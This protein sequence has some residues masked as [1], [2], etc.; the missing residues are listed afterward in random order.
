MD[1]FQ[2]FA[3]VDW[4]KHCLACECSLHI[5]IRSLR[6]AQLSYA[7]ILL[8]QFIYT[9]ALPLVQGSTSTILKS[10]SEPE[11]FLDRLWLIGHSYYPG[12]TLF[13]TDQVK[14]P[15]PFSEIL[16]YRDEIEAFKANHPRPHDPEHVET[17]STRPRR[18]SSEL[19]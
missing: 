7:K 17:T 9:A 8:L 16:H 11:T 4:H 6:I 15:E 5:W 18:I 19:R 3:L 1:S 12:S 10:R 14:I 13:S 2:S